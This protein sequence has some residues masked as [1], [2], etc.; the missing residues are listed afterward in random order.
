MDDWDMRLGNCRIRLGAAP[1]RVRRCA[2]L[3]WRKRGVVVPDDRRPHGAGRHDHVGDRDDD[4]RRIHEARRQEQAAHRN[5]PARRRRWLG[6]NPAQYTSEDGEYYLNVTVGGDD[7]GV[8]Y[9]VHDR[10]APHGVPETQRITEN[11]WHQ[12]GQGLVGN[13]CLAPAFATARCQV[14]SPRVHSDYSACQTPIR[15]AGTDGAVKRGVSRADKSARRTRVRRKER[16][17][18]HTTSELDGPT[19]GPRVSFVVGVVV[20]PLVVSVVVAW[21]LSGLV[22]K[23]HSFVMGV[24][25]WFAIAL[26]STVVLV[27]GR[28]VRP[29]PAAAGHVVRAHAGVPRS[30]AVALPDGVAQRARRLSCDSGSPHARSGKPTDTPADAAERVLELVIALNLHDRLT[31]GH[32]ERVRA[33]T[34]MIGEEMGLTDGRARPPA[35]V[36]S[37]ARHRQAAYLGRDPQQA[38]QVDRRRVRARSSSTRARARAGGAAVGWLGDSA[39]AVWEHHERWDGRGYPH[40]LAG[41]DI[42]LAGRIVAVADTYDVI[43]SVR[44]YKKAISPAEARAE[45]T[46]CAGTQFDPAVVRAFMNLSLG[47]LRLAMGPLSWLAQL[48]L[49][50]T[51]VDG[52]CRGRHDG[53]GDGAG[54]CRRGVA[55]ARPRR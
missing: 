34:Q 38:R 25:R 31:R 35:L 4:P 40:G 30:G 32:S 49:F 20:L 46:R 29:P 55:R 3:Q 18:N 39:R 52:D 6:V 22:P 48:P 8:W 1:A 16:C 5:R 14:R 11:A 42:S 43:T 19:V 27:G 36:G 21:I 33:Y 53:R 26:A 7:K 17:G 24:A 51:G 50:P 2:R 15:D 41:T 13:G 9:R 37:A 10:H 12:V 45:L 54:R 28:Q 47:R 23:P 44:S